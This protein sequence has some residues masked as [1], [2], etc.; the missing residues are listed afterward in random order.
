MS[1]QGDEGSRNRLPLRMSDLHEAFLAP[2]GARE[3][4]GLEVEAGVLDE[5]TG[6]AAPY[7]GPHGMAALLHQ[8]LREW[9]GSPQCAGDVLTGVHLPDGTKLTLEHG[10]QLEYSPPPADDLVTLVTAMRVTMEALATLAQQ[11]GLAIVPGGNLP[12][13]R[14][15]TATWVPTVRG[16][17]M[18]TYFAGLGPEGEGAPHIMKLSTSTQTTLDYLSE[19]DL[20]SKLRVQVAASPVVAALLV[21]S[22]LYA[23]HLDGVLSHRCRDWL[24]MDPRR[25]GSPRP[26]LR[27]P[28]TAKALTDWALGMPM[29]YRRGPSGYCLAGPQTFAD[30]LRDGFDDGTAPHWED[31][32]SHL[33]QIYTTVRVRQ[34]L[35]TRA[36]DGPPYPHVPAVPALWTGLTYHAPSRAA[37]WELLRHYTPE[38]N[39][40]AQQALP[41]AG[42]ATRLGGDSVR[43]LARHLLGLARAG[44]QARI[45]AGLE[46]PRALAFL[47]PLNEILDTN[48]TFAEQ[49]ARR[50]QTTHNNDPVRYITAHRIPP[51]T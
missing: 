25:V 46:Q 44:L 4:I 45:H 7:A 31:W 24:R 6:L 28:L 10:G 47:D 13:N 34:T 32:L 16:G 33:D 37:A 26:A 50:W 23:G 29:I 18:R 42:L 19:D 38:E 35:E 3:R 48:E 11:H 30:H 49:T 2:H 9:G 17:V 51:A 41:T 27:T 15:D 21:N 20:A 36:P 39:N 12:F 1:T 40:A 5:T 14:V 22:P 43:D 8:V